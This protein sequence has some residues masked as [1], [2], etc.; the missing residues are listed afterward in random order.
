MIKKFPTVCGRCFNKAQ[1]PLGLTGAKG[2]RLNY[3]LVKSKM[4]HVD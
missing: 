2:K 4:H 1:E 3:V